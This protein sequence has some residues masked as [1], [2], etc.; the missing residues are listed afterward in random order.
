MKSFSSYISEIVRGKSFANFFH[1]G[2]SQGTNV[3]IALLATPYL[4]QKLGEAEFGR[5]NLTLSIVLLLSVLVNY[6]FNLNA[7]KRI[8]LI[9]SNVDEMSDLI[10]SVLS[11]RVIIGIFISIVIFSSIEVFHIFGHTG[12]LVVFS[13]IVLISEALLPQFIL[14]GLDKLKWLSLANAASKIIYLITLYM[15]IEKSSDS[16]YVNFLFGT[17]G[18]LVNV[19]LVILIFKHLNLK[20]RVQTLSQ[21]K[22]YLIGNFNF[23]ISTIAGQVSVYG[24]LIILANF[25]SDTELGK[26][27]LAQRVAFLLR[28]IPVFLAQAIL[29]NAS[30]IYHK[31]K[32]EFR[33]Y[34]KRVSSL[35]LILTAI[36]CLAVLAFS[37]WII[38]VVGGE[39]VEESSH[40][41]KILGFVPFFGMLNIPNM[42]E[43]LAAEKQAV[44][45]KAT[46][47]V[48]IFMLIISF[49]GATYYGSKGMAF[50]LIITEL[51]SFVVHSYLLRKD[52]YLKFT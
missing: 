2:L 4:Y 25:V 52:K 34:I 42:I 48:A 45:A 19:L 20:F 36:I 31:D 29:Q 8:A 51:V 17:S 26:Y 22:T 50:A 9:K 38:Y 39:Y 21:I 3:L 28:L 46:W 6:G 12:T 49:F 13:L 41:L 27:S 11:F 18:L 10:S 16:R 47:V 15:F 44:L 35:G 7:P 32:L 33:G 5:V 14:Q 43:I 24:G 30:R 1:L 37:K 40:L 23:F